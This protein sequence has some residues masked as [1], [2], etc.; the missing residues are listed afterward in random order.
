MKN[1]QENYGSY[2]YASFA[3]SEIRTAQSQVLE[4]S[5]EIIFERMEVIDNTSFEG[6][7]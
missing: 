1:F 7:D 5:H 2:L 4:Q 6:R 3:A